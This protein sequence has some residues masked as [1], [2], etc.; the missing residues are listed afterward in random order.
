MITIPKRYYPM[1]MLCSKILANRGPGTIE[2]TNP[3]G[4]GVFDVNDHMN[5]SRLIAI[6]LNSDEVVLCQHT[7]Q[8][9]IKSIN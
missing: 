3:I 7:H 1:I 4:I 8:N 6:I 5:V 2:E 9:H